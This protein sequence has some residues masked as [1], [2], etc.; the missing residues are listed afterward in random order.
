MY[1]PASFI[2]RLPH[3][4]LALLA[5]ALAPPLLATTAAPLPVPLVAGPGYTG[6]AINDDN[7]GFA[8]SASGDTVAIGAPDIDALPARAGAVYVYVRS[9]SHWLQQAKL[10]PPAGAS[11]D[12]FGYS[13]ALDGNT[14]L[15]GAPGSDVVL[16]GND[17]GAAHV[18]VRNAGSWS[19]QATLLP[20]DPANDDEFGR[21]VAVAGNYALVGAPFNSAASTQQG[22]AYVFLRNGASWSQQVRLLRPG[23]THGFEQFGSAVALTPDTAVVGA[24]LADGM[25]QGDQ[26]QAVVYTRTAAVWSEADVLVSADG[27]A[28]DHFG[29]AVAIS[30]TRIAVGAPYTDRIPFFS[31]DDGAIYVFEGS[32]ASG[33]GQDQKLA[34]GLPGE[35]TVSALFGWSV[36]L[37]GDRVLGGAPGNKTD[38][39]LPV[40]ATYVYQYT[41]DTGWFVSKRLGLAD[42]RDDVAYGMGRAVALTAAAAFASSGDEP[43]ILD[44]RGLVAVYEAS[45]GFAQSVLLFGGGRGGPLGFALAVDGETAVVG[46]YEEDVG[47]ADEHGA[48]YLYVRQ[49]GVWRLQARLVGDNGSDQGEKLDHFGFAVAISGDTVVVGAPGVDFFNDASQPAE[50]DEGAAYVFV[51]SGAVWSQQAKLSRGLQGQPGEQFGRAVAIAGDTIAIGVP[52]EDVGLAADQGAVRVF[53][54][55]GANWSAAQTL[56]LGAA[57][58]AGDRF[59]YSLAL[60]A[61]TLLAAAPFDQVAGHAEQGSVALFPRNGA[62]YGVPQLV[63]E[64]AAGAAMDY[65]GFSLALRGDRALVGV[66]NDDD[67][68]TN[69]GT[70]LLL[71]RPAPGAAWSPA[72]KRFAADGGAG[73][74]FGVAVALTDTHAFIGAH[75]HQGKG[76]VYQL[77]LAGGPAAGPAILAPDGAQGDLFGYAVAADGD[78][79]LVGALDALG[80]AGTTSAMGALYTLALTPQAGALFADGFE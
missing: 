45:Q 69:A 22:A 11:G 27:K 48:A 64:G 28:G 49:N 36:A 77:D 12:R 66:F 72:G 30:G 19:L 41:A 57:G 59:G 71:T 5:L 7:Y 39:A 15:I 14:L 56:T 18:F 37:L 78:L 53:L 21:A 80:P 23:S 79:V 17:R 9:G 74:R 50:S 16:G 42:G 4:A 46:A 43:R 1:R 29:H 58:A 75:Y 62:S 25:A 24:P 70:A 33:W 34:D 10:L 40:G 60:S 76:A 68:L 26:G 38:S 13:V 54:R 20:S 44:Q 65:F 2:T 63:S 6:P 35:A 51:R 47:S 52:F 8:L 3:I 67:L 31:E 61:D 32:A 55:S 73:A